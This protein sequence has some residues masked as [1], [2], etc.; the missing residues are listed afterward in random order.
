MKKQLFCEK[1]KLSCNSK[2]TK[3]IINKQQK[4]G[5]KTKNHNGKYIKII[6][7]LKIYRLKKTNKESNKYP[8]DENIKIKKKNLN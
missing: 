8:T 1:K 3:Q 2:K 7:A 4:E 5:H 6:S